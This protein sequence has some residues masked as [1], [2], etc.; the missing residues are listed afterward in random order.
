MVE[1]MDQAGDVERLFSW[2]KAPMVHYRE[3]APKIEVAGAVAAWPVVHKAAVQAGVA[4]EDSPAPHG[5]AAARER[6]ARDRRTL[7]TEAA[8]ALREDPPPGTVRDAAPEAVAALTRGRMEDRPAGEG[9]LSTLGQ[10]LQA[11][12][13]AGAPIDEP[14]SVRAARG[15]SEPLPV[16]GAPAV[17]FDESPPVAPGDVSPTTARFAAAER[18][19]GRGALLGGEYR[20]GERQE[21]PGR[22][23]ADRADRSLDAVFSRLSGARDQLPDPRGR[24]RTTPGLGAVFG[25]LR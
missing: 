19:P 13:G 25:R 11:E 18:E 12:R 22:R 21:A 20:G 7:P 24:S 9:L 8:R 5:Y 17:G 23:V 6:I 10:R 3:F 16:A 2:F 4:A 14:A 1:S 15:L